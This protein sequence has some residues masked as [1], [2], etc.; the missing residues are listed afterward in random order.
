M[1]QNNEQKIRYPKFHQ[2]QLQLHLCK[3][4]SLSLHIQS[5]H[6][7]LMLFYLHQE[8]SGIKSNYEESQFWHVP[9]KCLQCESITANYI[10]IRVPL[11]FPLFLPYLFSILSVSIFFLLLM[12][13]VWVFVVAA[14]LRVCWSFVE[15]T[16][17]KQSTKLE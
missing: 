1:T 5:N 6:P 7:S 2:C 14:F 3:Y 16:F 17:M 10:G 15:K 9:L 12:L 13:P 11:L 8:E 4:S